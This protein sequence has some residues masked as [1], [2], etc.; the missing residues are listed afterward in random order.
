M[1]QKPELSL[2]LAQ[3]IKLEDR[4]SDPLRQYFATSQEGVRSASVMI[5]LAR[6]QVG[7]SVLITKRTET[8][9]QHKGQYAFPGG[10]HDLQDGNS[11]HTALRET[12][13]EMG[14][15]RQMMEVVG[16]LPDFRSTSGFQV[17]PVIALATETAERLPMDLNPHEIA[18][19]EWIPLKQL[20]KPEVYS[21]EKIRFG[22]V[23]YPTHVYLLEGSQG[24][25]RVWGLTAALLKNF[26]DRLVQV[27]RTEQDL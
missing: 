18:L 23:S 20:R 26:L 25:H 21:Q 27:V 22:G 19:A 7:W 17:T 10:A 1:L 24:P 9:D 16:T 15:P 13:E 12:E 6:S 2:L 3:A 11:S 5:L 14:I 8:V 4:S